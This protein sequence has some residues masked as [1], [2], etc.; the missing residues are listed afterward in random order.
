MSIYIIY[1]IFN[2]KNIY[3]KYNKKYNNTFPF[4][5]KF[6]FK[7]NYIIYINIKSIYKILKNPKLI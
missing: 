6:K 5:Y 2:M 1:N 3:L 7:N 4:F